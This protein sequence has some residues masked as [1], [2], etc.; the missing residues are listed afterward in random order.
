MS[1]KYLL[2]NLFVYD[3]IYIFLLSNFLTLIRRGTD[4]VPTVK[5]YQIRKKIRHTHIRKLQGWFNIPESAV[6]GA[7]GAPIEVFF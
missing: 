1:K 3:S 5:C 6:L 4:P 7:L 2:N